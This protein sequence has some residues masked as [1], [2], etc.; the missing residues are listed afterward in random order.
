MAKPL[1]EAACVIAFNHLE[2]VLFVK[3]PKTAKA[4]ANMMVFPGGK[5][6]AGD[7]IAPPSLPYPHIPPRFFHSAV[8]ELF[9]EVDLALTKPRLY[10]GLDQ[11]AR[12]QWRRD[13]ENKKSDFNALLTETKATPQY[14]ALLPYKQLITPVTSPHRFNTWFFLAQVGPEDVTRSEILPLGSE[15]DEL[16]WLTPHDAWHGYLEGEYNFATPQLYLLE[17][18]R[19]FH[20][21]KALWEH[22]KRRASVPV[23]PLL[24]QRLPI[25]DDGVITSIFNGDPLHTETGTPTNPL[26]RVVLHPDRTQTKVT[27]V[28]DTE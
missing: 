11:A 3:R 15:L 25:E 1:R 27:L 21:F 13:I 5:V 8:R 9:E 16:L 18:L 6:D 26:H 17:D 23:E 10:E 7:A 20:D 24:A 28:P 22:T 14:E 2:Q 12:R 19:R 4:W